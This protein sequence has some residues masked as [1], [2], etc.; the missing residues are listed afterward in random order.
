MVLL[1]TVF[2]MLDHVSVRCCL[3]S[4]V[5]W[6]K[7]NQPVNAVFHPSFDSQF[8]LWLHH[9]IY[10]QVIQFFVVEMFSVAEAIFTD[11][12]VM[13]AVM[14]FQV[15]RSDCRIKLVRTIVTWQ[16]YVQWL[17][18]SLTILNAKKMKTCGGITSHLKSGTFSV[19]PCSYCE[20]DKHSSHFVVYC[21][22]V[23]FRSLV[24]MV[25]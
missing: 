2:G 3:R 21:S 14:C 18:E 15:C 25:T 5:S 13:S 4:S 9:C 19:T 8:F 12:A 10:L 1:T 23:Q 11:A 16:F 20:W 22:C 17:C 6:M 7:T 24:S